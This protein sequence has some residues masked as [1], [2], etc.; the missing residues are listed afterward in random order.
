[1]DNDADLEHLCPVGSDKNIDHGTS[2]AKLQLC[3]ATFVC[4]AF[5][6]VEIVGKLFKTGNGNYIYN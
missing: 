2:R 1:M 6:A 4:I 3:L 5:I